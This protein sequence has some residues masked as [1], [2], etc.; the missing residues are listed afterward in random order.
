MSEQWAEFYVDQNQPGIV[1]GG[2][3]DSMG[4]M[5]VGVHAKEV[6]HRLNGFPLLEAQLEAVKQKA[7]Y[8]ISE[9]KENWAAGR[10]SID[11][12]GAC[13]DLEKAIGEGED[14]SQ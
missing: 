9:Y 4:G 3:F 5:L 12:K 13:D 11:C 6:C 14:A 7:A 1:R 8:F 10:V 2:P